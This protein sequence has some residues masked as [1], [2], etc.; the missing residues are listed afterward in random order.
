M[1]EN[2][3]RKAHKSTKTTF[4]SKSTAKYAVL[5]APCFYVKAAGGLFLKKRSTSGELSLPDLQICIHRDGKVP[6]AWQML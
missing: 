4:V 2:N 1:T 5:V 3:R 6:A